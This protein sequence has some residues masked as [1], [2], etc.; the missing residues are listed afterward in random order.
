M[1]LIEIVGGLEKWCEIIE[2]A[3]DW[4]D[5][6]MDAMV[7]HSL[8]WCE[9][10]LDTAR[11]GIRDDWRHLKWLNGFRM[12]S[13]VGS[14][15]RPQRPAIPISATQIRGDTAVG[16]THKSQPVCSWKMLITALA[17]IFSHK[18]RQTFLHPAICALEWLHAKYNAWRRVGGK[19]HGSSLGSWMAA[20]CTWSGHDE[21][22]E[23]PREQH[24][25]TAPQWI[26][27]PQIR[28]YHPTWTTFCKSSLLPTFSSQ[29][30]HA[31]RSGRTPGESRTC[32][33]GTSVDRPKQSPMA[34]LVWAG[35]LGETC[36]MGN[37]HVKYILMVGD[38]KLLS[39]DFVR[40]D[41]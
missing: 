36:S 5:Y 20:V 22:S 33:C 24:H 12:Y 8:R 27:A 23:T 9:V 2:V 39:N 29:A 40:D 32:R 41:E 3:W 35:R 10:W 31:P 17:K 4:D 38:W 26:H 15:T 6:E 30:A 18:D 34:R 11:N 13:T 14:L 28:M 7:W 37:G 21:S 19:S 1:R 25:E 16:E